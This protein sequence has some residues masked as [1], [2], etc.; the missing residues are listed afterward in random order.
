MQAWR[1]AFGLKPPEPMNPPTPINV[2]DGYW[3]EEEAPIETKFDTFDWLG[4]AVV[5]GSRITWPCDAYGNTKQ[6]AVGVISEIR[7]NGLTVKV[8]RRSRTG[9]PKAGYDRSH[10]HLTRVGMANMV[11]VP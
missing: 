4:R 7:E 3:T 8:E 5:V 11:M 1:R 2:V 10:I 6:M 9:A